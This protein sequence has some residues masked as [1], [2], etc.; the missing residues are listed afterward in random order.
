MHGV[1]NRMHGL[2]KDENL[3]FLAELANEH[4]YLLASHSRFLPCG[5]IYFG[6]RN[7]RPILRARGQKEKRKSHNWSDQIDLEHAGA[8]T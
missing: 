2:F 3:I 4:Q 6:V 7:N 8:S 1:A 5:H